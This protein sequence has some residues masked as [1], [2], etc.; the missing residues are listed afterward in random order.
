MQYGK[1]V[2]GDCD[3]PMGGSHGKHTPF[4]SVTSNGH[5]SHSWK[6]ELGSTG[7]SAFHLESAQ[8]S[9]SDNSSNLEPATA[10]EGRETSA[11]PSGM[12]QEEELSSV[13]RGDRYEAKRHGPPKPPCN[14]E[15]VAAVHRIDLLDEPPDPKLGECLMLLPALSY[16]FQKTR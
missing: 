10:C 4:E 14:A 1:R 15:R 7:D 6:T 16:A 5:R 12:E 3:T 2:D 9:S 13:L 8:H 11:A